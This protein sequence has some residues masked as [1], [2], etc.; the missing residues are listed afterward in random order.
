MAATTPGG[1]EGGGRGWGT[2]SD[3]SSYML[4]N[5]YIESPKSAA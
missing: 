4:F 2:D 3:L 1:G 5:V